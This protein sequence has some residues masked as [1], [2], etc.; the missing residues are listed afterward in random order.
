MS[1]DLPESY[2]RPQIKFLK[3]YFHVHIGGSRKILPTFPIISSI[4]SSNFFVFFWLKI[5]PLIIPFNTSWIALFF[6]QR[7]SYLPKID[8]KFVP[9]KRKTA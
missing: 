2:L 4:N 3:T 1:F 6:V 7:V 5:A 8:D 9:I